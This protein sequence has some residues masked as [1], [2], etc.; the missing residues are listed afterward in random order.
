MESLSS[1]G[2][3]LVCRELSSK[4]ESKLDMKIET[5]L[6]VVILGGLGLLFAACAA[7]PRQVVQCDP[8]KDRA[9]YE[10]KLAEPDPANQVQVTLKSD[11]LGIKKLY[12]F[13][14]PGD[15]VLFEGDI[16]IPTNGER[17]IRITG[18]SH[19]WPGGVI[20]YDLNG[21]PAA[22]RVTQAMKKIEATGSV[23]FVQ[24]TNQSDYIKFEQGSDPRLGLSPVGRQGGAQTITLG[25]A[26]GTGVAMHEILHSLGLWH[27]QSRKDRDQYVCILWDNIQTGARR[28]F[29]QHIHDGEDIGKYDFDSI[30]HYFQTA[31]SKDGTSPTI[32][33]K[34]PFQNEHIGQQDHLSAGDVA[35]LANIYKGS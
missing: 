18:R 10:R 9:A 34:P 15:R 6:N 1:S 11:R 3:D 29:D 4:A 26:C 2:L 27:E 21:L 12:A 5:S 8:A 7:T 13:V 14:A 17:G 20:P 32:S 24:R 16:V 19:V 28:Q 25:F 35:T 33:P 23:R 22:S 31:F 30:M